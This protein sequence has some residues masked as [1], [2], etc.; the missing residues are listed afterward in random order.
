[1]NLEKNNELEC[2]I[3]SLELDIEIIKDRISE[4][5]KF[6]ESLKLLEESFI[7]IE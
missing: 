6:L 7:D 4:K 5:K 2:L 3:D 1:M